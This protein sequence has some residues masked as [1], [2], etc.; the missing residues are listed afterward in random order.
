[1]EITTATTWI[2]ARRVFEL[3]LTPEF[4]FHDPNEVRA[5]RGRALARSFFL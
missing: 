1:M 3:H 5:Q 4:L 2:Y